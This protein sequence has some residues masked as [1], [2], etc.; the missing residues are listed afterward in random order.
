MQLHP[1]PL[2]PYTSLIHFPSPDRFRKLYPRKHI[3]RFCN[4]HALKSAMQKNREGSRC[5]P[6]QTAEVILTSLTH[7]IKK[8]KTRSISAS[9]QH[10]DEG[11]S[12]PDDLDGPRPM[13]PLDPFG[14]KEK[15]CVY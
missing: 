8:P 1:L 14:K 10:S 11:R 2:I 3:S 13:K 9:T 4:E 12:T 15:L 6:P 7:Y 5:P